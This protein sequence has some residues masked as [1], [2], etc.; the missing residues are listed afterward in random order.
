[1]KKFQYAMIIISFV[2]AVGAAVANI[3]LEKDFVWPALAAIWI[4]EVFFLQRTVNRYESRH[5]IKS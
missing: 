5:G 2:C 1:M 3:Y 4:G